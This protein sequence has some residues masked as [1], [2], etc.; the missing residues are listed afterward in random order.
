MTK[1]SLFELKRTAF[2]LFQRRTK[3][4]PTELTYTAATITVPSEWPCTASASGRLAR[5]PAIPSFPH[6]YPRTTQQGPFSKRVRLYLLRASILIWTRYRA[7]S[8]SHFSSLLRLLS[9]GC[10]SG[11]CAM[12]RDIERVKSFQFLHRG[13]SILWLCACRRDSMRLATCGSDRLDKVGF[14]LAATTRLY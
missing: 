5:A 7:S 11:I 8:V 2:Q 14:A 6:G 9:P 12:R 10:G 1:T 4:S 13:L 3:R